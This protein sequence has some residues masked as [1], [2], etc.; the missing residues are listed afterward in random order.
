MTWPAATAAI[1]LLSASPILLGGVLALVVIPW[2]ATV[3]DLAAHRHR[4]RIGA[5][6]RRWH[7]AGAGIVAPVRFARNVVVGLLRAL[8]AAGLALVGVAVDRAI[9]HQGSATAFRDL[10]IRLTGVAMG[11]VL[12]LPAR[13]AGRSFRTDLG[14]TVVADRLMEGRRRPGWR[15]VV[16]WVVMVAVVAFA[17]WLDPELWPLT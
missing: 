14:A 7:D 16:F 4:Q 12:I 10:T 3:G 13:E 5:Q 15:T 6:R 9:V 1:A 8:P 17:A 2:L 11:L